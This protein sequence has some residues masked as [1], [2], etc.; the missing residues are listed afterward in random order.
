[1]AKNAA[2]MNALSKVFTDVINPD[3]RVRIHFIFLQWI[4]KL[5]KLMEGFFPVLVANSLY[6]G[7]HRGLEFQD[8][9]KRCVGR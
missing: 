6:S 5:D 1:M 9:F 4:K 3:S 2:S 7:I 8:D